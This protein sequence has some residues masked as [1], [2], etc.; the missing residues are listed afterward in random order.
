MKNEITYTQQGY[1][2]LP[3]LKLPEQPKVVIGIWGRRHERYIK[4]HHKL[5]YF[6]L[7]TSCKLTAYL[8][9]IDKDA[10]EMFGRL[11]EQLANQEG[12][13]EPIKADNQMLWVKKMNCIRNQIT[14]IVNDVIIYV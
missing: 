4:Q 7:L 9:D 6:D 5:R 14:E 10:A 13:T 12:I 2:F 1:Y 3:D 11:V 8:A